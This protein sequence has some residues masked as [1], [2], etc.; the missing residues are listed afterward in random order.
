[1]NKGQGRKLYS[2]GE[3][4]RIIYLALRTGGYMHRAKRRRATEKFIERIMLAVTSESM[5]HVRLRPYEDGA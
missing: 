5:R 2:L 4:Y 1:M 3:S